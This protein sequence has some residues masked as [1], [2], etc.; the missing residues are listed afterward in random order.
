MSIF[1]TWLQS[2][3]PV[4]LQCSFP[5]LW[6]MEETS[7]ELPNFSIGIDLL[8]PDPTS[9]KNKAEKTCKLH[10]SQIF[11]GRPA[12]ANFGFDFLHFPHKFWAF[13]SELSV[14]WIK[15]SSSN[16]S[17]DQPIG[18]FVYFFWRCKNFALY[19]NERLL[20]AD[21]C[22]CS[23]IT[24]FAHAFSCTYIDLWMHTGS[25]ESTKNV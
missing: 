1:F 14:N 23:V 8:G 5:S 3:H 7:K 6:N 17:F 9:N 12:A 25:L 13:H 18:T 10:V 21:P 16:Q 19:H 15:C 22:C 11:V 24:E 4:T 20:H 2:F